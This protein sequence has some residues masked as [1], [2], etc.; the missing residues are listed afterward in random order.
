MKRYFCCILSMF[1]LFYVCNAD[2][3]EEV[4]DGVTFYYT[5]SNGK[6][7]VKNG[8]EEY[9]GDIIVPSTLGG[10]PVTDISLYQC[11]AL[12]SI[13]IPNTI[14]S[15]SVYECTLL[16]ELYLPDSV[17]YIRNLNGNSSLQSIRFPAALSTIPNT[18]LY[19]C[20][21]LNAIVWPNNL[22]TIG[23][24][25][26][27]ECSSLRSIQLPSTLEIIGENAFRDTG[28]TSITIPANVKTIGR[29]PFARCNSLGAI[30]VE[31]GNQYYKVVNGCLVS[32]QGTSLLAIP[33]T[34]KHIDIPPDVVTIPSGI[35]QYN[36]ILGSVTF[37]E[38]LVSIS[39]Y[40]FE[41]CTSLK[42]IV[43]PSTLSSIEMYAFYRC[44]FE[45]VYFVGNVPQNVASSAFSGTP[46]DMVFYAY[47]DTTGWP[48]DGIWQNRR[49]ELLD[50]NAH[51][52]NY[53]IVWMDDGGIE[54]DSTVVA[55]G[56]TPSHVAPTRSATLPPYRWVFT[57]WTPTLEAAVSN[58]TYTAT[59][60]KVA[61]LALV[62]SGWTVA[63]GD[64][65]VGETKHNV[66][67]PGGATVTINGVSVTGAGGGGS[68]PSPAFAAG[69]ASE[70]VKF[71]QAEGGKWTITA[72][73]EM[74]NESR[75]TDV[76][77]DQ[78]K[79]YSGDT[80]EA[81]EAETEPISEGVT[82]EERNSAVKTVI[83]ITPGESVTGGKFF[84]V[85]FGE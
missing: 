80:I 22:K 14:T 76:S 58:T 70:I 85:K 32:M 78:I 52:T 51:L 74:S 21:N 75:G 82:I 4:V 79:V 63:D 2:D 7:T 17:T 68:A 6:A 62:E 83:K 55:G 77:E 44:G 19:R 50:R 1:T 41:G 28:L 37:P 35:F 84:K 69:G 27:A 66:T 46:S 36:Q 49:L 71:A 38:G 29:C 61:D 5:V 39:L 59:F 42:S 18:C 30:L 13:V 8:A 15:I 67:I 3:Y 20:G 26:F 56:E 12:R 31:D 54:I 11:K 40:A 45:S 33:R 53:N 65:I 25:A 73:A 60:K 23:E 64:E 81:L 48:T 10:Y 34:V 57:G 43:L 72:F 47:D 9:V 24:S 16:T